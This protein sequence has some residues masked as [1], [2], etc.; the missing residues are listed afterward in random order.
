[1]PI[2]DSVNWVPIGVVYLTSNRLKPFWAGLDTEDYEQ[3]ETLLR[4]TFAEVLKYAPI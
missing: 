1:M 2:H 4:N 3:L